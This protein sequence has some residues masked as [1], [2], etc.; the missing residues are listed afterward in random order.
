MQR[1]KIRKMGMSYLVLTIRH[2]GGNML[3]SDEKKFDIC[4]AGLPPKGNRT[5]LF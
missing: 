2:I 4:S 5:Y 1:Y 3:K